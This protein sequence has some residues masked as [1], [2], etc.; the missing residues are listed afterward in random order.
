MPVIPLPDVVGKDGTLLP[1]QIV[2]EVPKLKLGV[3]FGVTVTLNVA[4]LAHWL[5]EGVKIYVPEF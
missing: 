2:N 5:P 4:W 3:M 1:A